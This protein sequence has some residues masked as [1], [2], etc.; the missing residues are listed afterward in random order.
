MYRNLGLK[1]SPSVVKITGEA[2]PVVFW[3]PTMDSYRKNTDRWNPFIL[4]LVTTN[5]EQKIINGE[6]SCR[7]VRGSAATIMAYVAHTVR[8]SAK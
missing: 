2:A 6:R 1:P 3:Q 8:L 5:V 4:K 7:G